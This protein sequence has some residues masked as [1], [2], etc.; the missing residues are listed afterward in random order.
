MHCQSARRLRSRARAS[1]VYLHPSAIL[2]SSQQRPLL[3]RRVVGNEANGEFQSHMATKTIAIEQVTALSDRDL[4]ELAALLVAIV[5]Q[6]ASVGYLPPLDPSEARTYWQRAIQA[7]N[8]VFLVARKDD[9]IVGTVQ[10]EYSTK[11]N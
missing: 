7:D 10:L 4:D 1:S 8:V 9:A 2:L 5:D 3:S 11:R 6:G